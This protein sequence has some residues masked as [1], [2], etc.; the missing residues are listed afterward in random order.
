MDQDAPAPDVPLYAIGDV[1]GRAD[2]LIALLETIAR[3][4]EAEG[5][6]AEAEIVALG[7]YVDRGE[8]SCGAVELLQALATDPEARLRCLM[9]NHERMM[10]D[11]LD[12]PEG[13]AARWP[14][15]GGDATLLSWGI[16]P[17]EGTAAM[18]AARLREALGPETEAWL[19]ALP[20]AHRSGDVVLAH[21]GLDPALPPEAQSAQ[22]LLWGA[23]GIHASARADGLW[24]VHGH[25]AGD[26]PVLAGRRIC[27]DTGA[28]YSDRLTAV[29]LRAGAAP[30]FLS[31]RS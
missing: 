13:P 19:R 17:T 1:H 18:R 31:A 20:L 25:V 29:A 24:V 30:R 14:R 16:D 23:P 7:D 3:D 9:G 26:E 2:L 15:Y 12:A 11:F 6:A 27:C 22:I 28:Y 8:D 10:L 5:I 21:A 4:A